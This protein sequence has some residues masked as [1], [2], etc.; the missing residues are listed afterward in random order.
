MAWR[1]QASGKAEKMNHT[2]K[3]NIAKLCQETHLHWHQVLPIA[4][5]RMRVAPRSGIQLSPYE[6]VYGQPFQAMTRVGAMYIDQKVKVKKYV[7]HLSQTL[8]VM[9]DLA[10]IRDLSPQVWL[11][12]CEPG[13]KV[14]LKTWKTGSPEGQ[15]EEEWTE[16]WDVLLTTPTAVTLAEIKSWIHHTR[17]KKAPENNGLLSLK[18]T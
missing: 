5:L 12:S 7:Q 6:I 3:K 11:H 13:D 1:P 10:G 4:L 8:A 14:S 17:V 9:S 18:K 2:L 15:L 16:P